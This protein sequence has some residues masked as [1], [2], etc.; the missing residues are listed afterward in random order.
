[1]ATARVQVQTP[2]GRHSEEYLVSQRT[3]L[4]KVFFHFCTQ[5]GLKRESIRFNYDG[6]MLQGDMTV[7]HAEIEQGVV[8]YALAPLGGC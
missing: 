7:G 8:L 5:F 1:M 6:T 2:C 3:R 4:S